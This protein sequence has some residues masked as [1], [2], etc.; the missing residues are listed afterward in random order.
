MRML[1]RTHLEREFRIGK[2]SR[3]SSVASMSQI[4]LGR[5]PSMVRYNRASNPI[6]A[7]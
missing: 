7:K 2:H 3:P 4:G 1:T 6:A 5:T